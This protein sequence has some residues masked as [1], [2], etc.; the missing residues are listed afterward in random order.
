[1][2][3]AEDWRVTLRYCGCASIDAESW[4]PIFEQHCQAANFSL[5]LAEMDDFLG[6]ILT[7]SYW[8]RR[9]EENLA[10]SPAR[11]MQVWPT[12]FPDI[13]STA[14]YALQPVA[15]ANFVYGGRLGNV[16]PYDGWKYRGRG[17][18]MATGLEA[19]QLIDAACGTD[20]V[21]FP[22][23]LALPENALQTAIAWW[24]RRVPDAAMGNIVR[25]TKAVQGGDQDLAK[26][27][28]ITTRAKEKLHG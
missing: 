11:L 28:S 22:D 4:S 12:H 24:E 18:I 9:L 17:L 16:T 20:Y 6:Q 21:T 26:R 19:Y 14:P 5:G 23:S 1:M 13:E 8:L 2:M 25:V 10:Y 3:S 7:E 15:L 27:N